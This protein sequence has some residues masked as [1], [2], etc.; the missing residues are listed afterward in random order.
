[1]TA[2]FA[3]GRRAIGPGQPPYVIAEIGV[4]HDGSVD[5]AVELVHAAANAGADAI[6]VQWFCTETLVA[7]DAQRA[8]YQGGKDELQASLLKPLELT[9]REFERVVDAA[10]KA[11]VDAIVTV[12]SDDLVPAAAQLAWDAWKVASPDLVHRPLLE[13]LAADGR[14]MILSSGA[15]TKEEVQRAFEWIASQTP[16]FLQC[17][18][19]YPTPEAC[20]SLGGIAAIASATGMVVGYSD[21]TRE[22]STGGLA[23]A[24]GAAILEKHLT[25]KTSAEGP[26]HEASL[27]PDAFAAYVSFAHRAHAAVGARDAKAP[28]PC[29]EDVR[30]VARQSIHTRRA[31]CKG[32]TLDEADLCFK[33]PGTGLEPWQLSEVLGRTITRNLDA[34]TALKREDVA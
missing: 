28:Q 20:A 24:A 30:A 4:N 9:E 5:R 32:E 31:M 2:T 22:E 19:A 27:E 34:L 14:P 16:A 8:K 18:S 13:A 17:V 23:V 33:R 21:H 29:E 7:P 15:A 10:K 26:D 12:F 6:K 25:W 11:G 3:I 1:M